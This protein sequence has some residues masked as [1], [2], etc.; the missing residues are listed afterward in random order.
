MPGGANRN[1]CRVG[2]T[3]HVSSPGGTAI[4]VS[5]AFSLGEA[6]RRDTETPPPPPS[7]LG[8][9]RLW[10]Q[11]SPSI[12]MAGLSCTFIT[13]T[14]HLRSSYI[15]MLFSVTGLSLSEAKPGVYH[16]G[17]LSEASPHQR[18]SDTLMGQGISQCHQH[19]SSPSVSYADE[20]W[21]LRRAV[22]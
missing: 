19:S 22:Q 17:S 7:N 12:Y 4:V 13:T 21:S 5:P 9:V 3:A 11:I 6:E 1:M 10:Y 16:N 18:I 14:E 20:A 8:E 15:F 2:D